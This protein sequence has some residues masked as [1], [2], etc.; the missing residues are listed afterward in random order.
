MIRLPKVLFI[1]ATTIA[2]PGVALAQD[3]EPAADP[4]ATPA[5]PSSDPASG[6]PAPA[7]DA[8]GG[9]SLTLGK[10]K[11]LIA[12]STASF[13]LSDGAEGEPITIAPSIW[14]GVSD[15]ITIGLTHDLG[16]T[17]WSPRPLAAPGI[18]VTGTD[19][20]CVEVYENLGLSGL[21]SLAQGKFSAA[22]HIGADV[23]KFDPFILSARVG[24]LGH[25][26]AHEKFSI[27]F[28][29]RVTFGIT[30]RDA[31]STAGLNN[32]ERFDVPVYGWINVAPQFGAYVHIGFN[33]PFD[34]LDEAYRIPVGAGFTYK[35]N[36]Q[37]S[38]GADFHFLNLIGKD[39]DE[40][41]RV[42]G[43]RLAYAI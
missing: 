38:A 4:S 37:F 27:V 18:C 39:G 41:L 25:Y 34:G 35:V 8:A 22:A 36:Q 30:E 9:V 1:A 24:L 7:A 32:K 5:D 21:V 10:G 2:I 11:V 16:S 26:A 43:V 20:G 42:L 6:E 3:P 23:G 14:Y 12:G 40:K 15:K 19:G 17:T 13:N 33:A 31:P 29:P 28:D